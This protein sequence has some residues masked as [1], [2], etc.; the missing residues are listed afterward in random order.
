[1]RC[2]KITKESG[3]G[4]ESERIKLKLTIEVEGV[5][6]DAEGEIF[7]DVERVKTLFIDSA[8][9]SLELRE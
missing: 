4:A 7:S 9:L 5:E 6:F 2:R 8:T 3:V 1:M